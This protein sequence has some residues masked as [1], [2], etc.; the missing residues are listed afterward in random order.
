MKDIKSLII[1][2]LLATC[3]FLFM[4]NA[5]EYTSSTI[6]Y[7]EIGRYQLSTTNSTANNVYETII[8]TKTGEIISRE[9]KSIGKTYR[10]N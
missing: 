5:I 6:E 2:F 7:P 10:R 8:D 1:G 3:M 9:E 4:G